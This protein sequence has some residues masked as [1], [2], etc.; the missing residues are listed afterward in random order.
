[1]MSTS[2]WWIFQLE[3]QEISVGPLKNI[4]IISTGLNRF[5]VA[6]NMALKKR[7][8]VLC[9]VYTVYCVFPSI[10]FEFMRFCGKHCN[11]FACNQMSTSFG[12][13]S[14]YRKGNRLKVS[15]CINL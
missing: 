15:A 7:V 13:K 11:D 6:I 1:M 3:N 12:C 2:K 5:C 4:K 14:A 8:C 9:I 10:C